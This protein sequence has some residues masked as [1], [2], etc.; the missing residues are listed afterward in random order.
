MQIEVP[1]QQS[2]LLRH[3]LGY[4]NK[5]MMMSTPFRNRADVK[6]HN[7]SQFSICEQH[8]KEKDSLLDPLVVE[9]YVQRIPFG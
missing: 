8:G 6:C 9:N 2:G 7:E 1:N 5:D 3:S 4:F